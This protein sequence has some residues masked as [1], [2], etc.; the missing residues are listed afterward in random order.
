[1]SSDDNIDKPKDGGARRT[2]DGDARQTKDEGFLSNCE[3]FKDFLNVVKAR[4]CS[5]LDKEEEDGI[6]GIM[7][8]MRSFLSEQEYGC[9]SK[10]AKVSAHSAEED[11]GHTK[12]VEVSGRGVESIKRSSRENG[13]SMKLPGLGKTAD[14]KGET[15]K[16]RKGRSSLLSSRERG[17]SVNWKSERSPLISSEEASSQSEYSSDEGEYRRRSRKKIYRESSSSDNSERQRDRTRT[18]RRGITN[19]VRGSSSEDSR[20]PRSERRKQNYI[21]YRQAPKLEKFT[22]ESG[23]D[24]EKFIRR[25][26]RYCKHNVRG[27][28]EFWLSVLE[29]HLEGRILQSFKMLCDHYDDYYDARDKLLRWHQDNAELRK[30]RYRKKFENARVMQDE[31]L[32]MFSLRLSSIFKTAY[33]N[34]DLNKSKKL[35]SQFKKVIPRRQREALN[36]QVMSHKLKNKRPNWEFIQRCVK[37]T[38]LDDEV[39]CRSDDSGKRE[40][41]EVEINLSRP[42][43]GHRPPPNMY[44]NKERRFVR[45]SNDECFTC[46][47]V[48]HYASE[49]R[50]NLGLCV[51]CGEK[52]HFI[53]DCP[54]K[55]E[56][57]NS[58]NKS[59]SYT[60][61]DNYGQRGFSH[62]RGS[63]GSNR[64]SSLNY[65]DRNN[66]N[67]SRFRNDNR[68]SSSTNYGTG[69][70]NAVIGNDRSTTRNLNSQDRYRPST[71]PSSNL[72]HHAPEF[73][74]Q[75]STEPNA[76]ISKRP[77][78]NPHLNW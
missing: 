53:V 66:G 19:N 54:N 30:R 33:P 43:E 60:K 20:R 56:G 37:L 78:Q 22:E 39:E 28:R 75:N 38:D 9:K 12:G 1:M 52:G 61:R 6:E 29:E 63:S 14:L 58:V 26:E 32:Y 72:S 59:N 40:K 68:R 65:R 69:A 11:G 18:S 73:R 7:Q 25:F 45:R 67:N 3:Y 71:V 8:G 13:E 77:L 17:K 64:S 31:S 74:P 44:R 5:K 21:D 2:K 34:H 41:R 10:T 76:N 47:R 23:Q 50:W 55:R 48:G 15:S 36:T 46:K 62:V 35:M 57:N 16:V 49:C 4:R 42:N 27:G 70:N 24:L 51:V